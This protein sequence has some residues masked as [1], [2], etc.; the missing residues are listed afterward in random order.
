MT[1]ESFVELFEKRTASGRGVMVRC[2]AHEDKSASLSVGR[3]NDGGVVLKC[4]ANCATEDVVARLGLTMSDLFAEPKKIPIN[5]NGH[6][7]KTTLNT[8]AVLRAVGVKPTID[9]IYSYTDALGRELYQAVRLK[10]KDFRQRHATDENKWAWNMEGVERV[11]YRLPEVMAAEEIWIVEG[12]KDADNLVALGFCATCNVGGAGKWLD[13]YNEALRGKKV[14]VCGDNDDPGQKHV[15]LVFDSVSKKAASVKVLK[16][17][18]PNK[19]ASDF[20]Q[21]VGEK[22]KELLEEMKNGAVPHYG[23]T[24]LPVYSMA[25]IEASYHRLVTQATSLCVDLS[26]WL[27]SLRTLRPLVPGN[28]ALFVADTG[29]GKTI[30]LQN[31]YSNFRHLPTLFF[32]L[33]L[34]AEELYERFWA[35]HSKLPCRDIEAEYRGNGCFGAEKVMKQFPGLYICPEPKLTVDNFEEI[36]FKSELKMGVKPLVVMLDYFQ[37]MRSSRR[38]NSR[39][40]KASEVAESVKQIAKTTGTIIFGASQIDRASGRDGDVGL[41]SA[42]DSGSLENSAGLVIGA[43]RDEQDQTLLILKVLKATKGGAGTEVFC[44]ID[45][46]KALIT[47]RARVSEYDAQNNQQE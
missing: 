4:F 3:S 11:L 39:Y 7:P 23:G 42:K 35:N 43:K 22:A 21:A 10:P 18:H 32:E 45:G 38:H 1:Y 2:P 14:V 31:V 29:I 24:R 20:I 37:L 26:K 33:E 36:I 8:A 44:N 19:D 25:D 13:G 27:P 16:M 5:G 47:E 12:E 30:L 40:E 9:V 17:P 41:H 15:E 6:K 46:A 28:F 34:T